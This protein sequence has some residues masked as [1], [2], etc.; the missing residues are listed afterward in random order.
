MQLILQNHTGDNI[1]EFTVDPQKLGEIG[2]LIYKDKYY[3]YQ[4]VRNTTCFFQEVNPPT[5]L[6]TLIG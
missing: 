1:H 6:R 4:T 3:T 5:E 2:I